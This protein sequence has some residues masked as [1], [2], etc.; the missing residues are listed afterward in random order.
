MRFTENE[1][2]QAMTGAGKTVV[3]ARRDVRRDV[4]RGRRD[5][6]EVWSAM[7][8]HERFTVLNALGDKILPVLV[9]LPEID[10]ATDTRPTFTVTEVTETVEGVV[11]A[12]LGAARRAVEVRA[13]VALVQQALAHLPVR[14]DPDVLEV[15]DHL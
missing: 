13:R 8:R 9:A 3:A 12:D 2:T 10:V 11:A 4:R 7:S 1:L 5:A 6:D 15:P 14:R